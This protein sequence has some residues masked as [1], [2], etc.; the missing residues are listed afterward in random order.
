MHISAQNM[1]E[2][3]AHIRSFLHR[4]R[5]FFSISIPKQVLA[6]LN[7]ECVCVCVCG[8][9][10]CDQAILFVELHMLSFLF[11][12]LLPIE[13]KTSRQTCNSTLQLRCKIEIAVSRPSRLAH[14]ND[15]FALFHRN[16]FQNNGFLCHRSICNYDIT[17]IHFR[18]T[19]AFLHNL[20]KF[21]EK[22][23]LFKLP[24]AQ[25]FC[26]L[27]SLRCRFAIHVNSLCIILISATFNCFITRFFDYAA[28]NNKKKSLDVTNLMHFNR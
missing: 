12:I 2:L 18:F 4:L 3:T 23:T 27:N 17:S 13:W 26:E 7:R 11:F 15:A 6:Y 22:I 10:I 25:H 28:T 9:F 16:Q 20:L 24:Q 14:L 19:A 1:P 5:F 8:Q 21:G